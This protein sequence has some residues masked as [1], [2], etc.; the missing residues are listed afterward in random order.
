MKAE[1]LRWCDTNGNILLTGKEAC[2]L[3]KQKAEAE[4]QRADM[5]EHE[6]ER[7]KAK[8]AEKQ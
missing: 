6:L 4:K 5:L 7:L 2:D 8:M 1:W 3:E